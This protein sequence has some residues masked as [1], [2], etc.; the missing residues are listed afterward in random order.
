MIENFPNQRREHCETGS[1]QNLMEYYGIKL[2]EDLAFGI[3]GGLYFLYCPF[4][5]Y[6]NYPFPIMRT[7]PGTVFRNV[8][9]RVGFSMHEMT[10]GNDKAKSIEVLNELVD[11]NIPVVLVVNIYTVPYLNRVL[12]PDNKLSFNGHNI[13]VI[14]REGSTYNISDCDMKLSDEYYTIEEAD[15]NI[16]RFMPGANAPHGRL[17]YFDKPDPEKFACI[18]YRSACIAGLKEVCYNMTN[19]PLPYFG[20]KGIKHM[21]NKI[22][23]LDQKH[24]FQEISLEL[25]FYYRIIEMA[26]TGGSGYRYIFARFLKECAG[27]FQDERFE[28]YSGTMVKAADSWRAFSV[29]I[30]HF[31]KQTGVTLNE[32]AEK[33]YTAASYEQ[34]AINSIKK[35]FLKKHKYL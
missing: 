21:A 30:M 11:Q 23:K 29:D 19:I 6:K 27:I 17:F 5:K 28:T 34:D 8:S 25:L 33:L 3:G 16:T 26:G 4:I 31:R 24:T 12:P 2:S 22:K 35:D 32:M 14:G 7:R 20:F 15:L 18:D 1:L 9:K 10:F 13:I